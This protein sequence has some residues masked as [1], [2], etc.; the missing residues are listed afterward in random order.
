MG[1]K[2]EEAQAVNLPKEGFNETEI[3]AI[4]QL[5]DRFKHP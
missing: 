1:L 3:K 4:L 5:K 2:S